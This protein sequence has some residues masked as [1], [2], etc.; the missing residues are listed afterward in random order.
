MIKKHML[1]FP[2]PG[3]ANLHILPEQ[4]SRNQ[5][6]EIKLACHINNVTNQF[7]NQL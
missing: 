6:D 1:C 4:Q 5:I 2:E 3:G 7:A